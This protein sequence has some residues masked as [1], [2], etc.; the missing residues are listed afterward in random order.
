MVRRYGV[1]DDQWKKIEGLVPGREEAVGMTAK[2]TGCSWR[3]DCPVPRI[4]GGICR[5]GDR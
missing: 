3:L 5:S 1:R 2:D 4:R